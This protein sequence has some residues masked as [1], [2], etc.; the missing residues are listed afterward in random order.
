MSY[1]QY[2]LCEQCQR[3]IIVRNGCMPRKYCSNACKQLAYRIRRE[4]KRHNAL[5]QQWQQY[6]PASQ[7]AL[8]RLLLLHGEEAVQ[9]ALEAI[10][11]L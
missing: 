6:S 1:F 8:E 10:Q 5:R 3:P 2:P 7:K 9:F 4:E 11:H